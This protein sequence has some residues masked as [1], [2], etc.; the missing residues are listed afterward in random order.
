MV[1]KKRHLAGAAALALSLTVAVQGTYAYLQAATQT[2]ANTFSSDKSI[3]ISL[4]EPDWDGYTFEGEQTEGLVA[5]SDEA[6]PCGAS[7]ASDHADLGLH[8]ASDY[9]PGD[10]IGKNPMIKNTS[11]SEAAWV[12]MAVWYYDIEEGVKTPVSRT[13]FEEKNGTLDLPS[14]EWKLVSA[15][16]DGLGELYVYQTKA[17]TAGE[18]TKP[19]FTKVVLNQDIGEEGDVL[20]EFSIEVRGYAVQAA[21]V[22][23]QEGIDEL[24]VLAG[25]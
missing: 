21:N 8:I 16:S 10:T 4:R 22:L 1:K 2:A 20:P 13:A 25:F 19:L 11:E 7:A 3:H 15:K 9:I 24:K 5:V 14:E 12:A 18:K 17:I 23:E 6:Y